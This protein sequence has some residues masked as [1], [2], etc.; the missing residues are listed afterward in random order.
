MNAG[1]RTKVIVGYV[2]N[3]TQHTVCNR[4]FVVFDNVNPSGPIN[5]TDA[6]LVDDIPPRT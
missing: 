6:G 2:A 3:L 5:K 1:P 4:Y